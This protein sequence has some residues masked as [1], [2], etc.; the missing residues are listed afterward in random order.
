M[1]NETPADSASD[2]A[3]WALGAHDRAVGIA[4]MIGVGAE[5]YTQDPLTL[6]PR[7]QNYVDRLPLSSF[8]QSDWITLHTDLTAYLGDLMVRRHNATWVK[9]SDSSSPVG[10]RY[11]IETTGIDGATYRMEPYDVSMEEFEHL[12]IE[13]T[14]MVA[15]AEAVLHVAPEIRADTVGD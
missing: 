8:E 14:R 10:Y 3:E 12:P 1:Q 13:I 7:L 15:N 2:I 9:V 5:R 11:L 4:E 6:L